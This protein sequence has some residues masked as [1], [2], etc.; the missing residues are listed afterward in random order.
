MDRPRAEWDE[1]GYACVARLALAVHGAPRATRDLDL[2]LD[3]GAFT[4]LLRAPIALNASA[5]KKR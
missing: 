4:A 2:K 5:R 3:M 1:V